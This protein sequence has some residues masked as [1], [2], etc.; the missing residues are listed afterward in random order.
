MLGALGIDEEV[1]SALAERLG[2]EAAHA[3]EAVRERQS[4]PDDG[5][6]D[7]RDLCSG[8]YEARIEQPW[9]GVRD[10]RTPRRHLARAQLRERAVRVHADE[11]G[12][13][14]ED[15]TMEQTLAVGFTGA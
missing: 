2:A 13:G 7:D 10:L 11:L 3:P 14:L 6:P 1:H 15:R 5:A 8:V 9:Q 4:R 12:H